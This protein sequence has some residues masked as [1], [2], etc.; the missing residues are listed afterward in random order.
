MVLKFIFQN[1][2]YCPSTCP[3]HEISTPLICH[4]FAQYI[5]T[6]HVSGQQCSHELWTNRPCFFPKLNLFVPSSFHKSFGL[7]WPII[8]RI[9]SS[10][11]LKQNQ[12]LL[13]GSR[14]ILYAGYIISTLLLV[15]GH[16]LVWI[17]SYH[18]KDEAVCNDYSTFLKIFLRMFYSELNKK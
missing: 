9:Y 13:Y 11:K 15:E 4:V 18:L 2:I 3:S 12:W 17:S 16:L 7:V 8:S 10:E 6:Q 1:I 5:L 14:I